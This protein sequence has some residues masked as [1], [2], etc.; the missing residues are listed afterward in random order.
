MQP[1][2]KKQKNVSRELPSDVYRI[3]FKELVPDCQRER[4][5]AKAA[6]SRWLKNANTGDF[7]AAIRRVRGHAADDPDALSK[8]LCECHHGF[9]LQ[10]ERSLVRA[11]IEADS[12]EVSNAVLDAIFEDTEHFQCDN[13][14]VA[15]LLF[16]E[17]EMF[18]VLFAEGCDTEE[19]QNDK[20]FMLLA[21]AAN[22]GA[23]LYVG[24]ALNQDSTFMRQAMRASCDP[25]ESFYDLATYKYSGV[26][27]P[28]WLREE[29]EVM[30]P[31][32]VKGVS[33]GWYPDQWV[34]AELIAEFDSHRTVQTSI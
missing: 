16:Y 30:R 3:L 11:A 13:A 9:T 26:A 31:T 33:K 32:L 25:A 23:I 18:N 29:Y 15:M 19:L 21:V 8:V 1:V 22:H 6:V 17:S 10:E 14:S 12:G 20:E 2:S 5:M 27:K 28:N 4:A 7:L 34:H 24:D